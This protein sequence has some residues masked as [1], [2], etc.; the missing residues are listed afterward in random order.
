MKNIVITGFMGTGKSTVGK[1]LAEGY[2]LDFV[3]TDEL[4][5]KKA[6]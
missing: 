5:E 6:G 2:G 1:M 3:D 4:I